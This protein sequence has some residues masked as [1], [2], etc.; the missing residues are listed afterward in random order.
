[1]AQTKN[2]I[3]IPIIILFLVILA[4]LFLYQAGSIKRIYNQEVLNSINQ[5]KGNSDDLLTENDIQSLPETVKKYLRYTG[6]IGKPRVQNVRLSFSGELKPNK[7]ADWLK[8]DTEQY[9]FFGE[10][11]RIV[12]IQ[13]N[14]LGLPLTGRD[15]YSTGK[16]HMLIKVAGL[17]PVADAKAPEMDKAA[18]V[19][20]FND[21]C[22][23]APAAL[24]DQ[25]ISWETIDAQTVR[26]TIT[27]QGL[28]V[29]GTLLFNDKGE[30]ISFFTN[31]RYY[32]PTGET[33]QQVGW[34]TPVSSYRSFNGITLAERGDA[35]WHFPEG[36]FTYAR[37]TLKEAGY[38]LTVLR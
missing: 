19:T 23:L 32:S 21:M 38:N 3:K 18:L 9:D 17:I 27:D 36:D 22:L 29:S 7:E 20:L 6:V 30:L 31:D 24:I 8:V 26:G 12:Y 34:S 1:M 5:V 28:K 14:T 37:F 13:S 16:G 25:R 10:L 15:L 35:V 2:F 4:A 33:Y 11:T